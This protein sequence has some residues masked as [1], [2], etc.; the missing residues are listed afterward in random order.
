MPHIVVD[1]QAKIIRESDDRIEVRDQSG[2]RLGYLDR[3]FSDED[4]ATAKRR[5]ESDETR[6][7]TQQVL[8]HIQSLN[9]SSL[10]RF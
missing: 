7:T 10:Q 6:F 2:N 4:I 3:G 5:M 9:R 8:D 1:E